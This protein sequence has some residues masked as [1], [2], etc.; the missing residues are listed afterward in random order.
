MPNSGAITLPSLADPLT[1]GSGGMFDGNTFSRLVASTFAEDN[2]LKIMM[3]GLTLY[4]LH[5]YNLNFI[6]LHMFMLYFICLYIS[7]LT[8]I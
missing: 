7:R 2:Y 1:F 5:F 4:I 3:V 6:I 8:K